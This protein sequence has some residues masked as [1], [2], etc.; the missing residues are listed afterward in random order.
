MNNWQITT[1]PLRHQQAATNKMQ[2]SKVGA[3]FMDMGTGKS[4]VTIMLAK[5]RE[6]KINKVVWCCPVSLKYNTKKQITTHTNCPESN[7]CVFD[8]KITD[9]NIPRAFWYIVGLE[10]IGSSDRVVMS[11]NKLVDNKTMLVVDESSFIKGHKA[12]RTNRLILIGETARYRLIL[13]GT[14]ISQ[15]VEDL[16]TQMTFLSDRILGYKSWYSFARKHLN[17]S[18]RYK[19]LIDSRNHTD[20]IGA[21]IAPY[22]YQVTKAECLDLPEK[23]FSSRT[24]DLTDQQAELYGLAKQR[25]E[26][27][28]T[29]Y[30]PMETGIA[31]YRLFGA[32]KAIAN[33]IVPKDFGDKEYD[34]NS[35]KLTTLVRVLC[36]IPD[37]PVVI[38]V[39]YRKTVNDVQKLLTAEFDV[40]VSRYDGS[41]TEKQKEAELDRWRN[42]GGYLISTASCG[43]YGL[44]LTEASYSVFLSNSFKYSE[45]IQAE[46]RLHRIGQKNQVHYIDIWSDCGIED[47]IYDAIARKGDALNDFRNEIEEIKELGKDKV[48]ALLRSL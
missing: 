5:L 43:G 11:L 39:N 27:D 12:K 10:S 31:I 7:I 18:E 44:T 6:A 48:L 37:E 21:K 33:G 13:N 25:F 32:L 8:Q 24:V 14:P 15:G 46:D 36:S 42:K 19:G 4:L 35:N 34:L 29:E 23:T 1:K 17:Y 2:P 3:L 22:V 38:W 26:D 28:L 40:N 30:D 20:W 16:Y 47:R 9:D 45:R 41:L